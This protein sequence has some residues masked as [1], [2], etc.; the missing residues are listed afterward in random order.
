MKKLLD[1][2]FRVCV[3]LH[4]FSWDTRANIFFGLKIMSDNMEHPNLENSLKL[5]ETEVLRNSLNDVVFKGNKLLNSQ[6][7]EIEEEENINDIMI[8]YMNSVYFIISIQTILIVGL[9][10]YQIFSFRKSLL[11]NLY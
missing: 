7:K 11:Q 5:N 8:G 1:G 10:I 6:Q 4:G 3:E 9:S 2:F